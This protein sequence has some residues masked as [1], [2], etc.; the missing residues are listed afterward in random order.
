MILQMPQYW[1]QLQ[2]VVG[3]L[4]C[5]NLPQTSLVDADGQA[6]AASRSREAGIGCLFSGRI[7]GG[8]FVGPLAGAALLLQRGKHATRL[9]ADE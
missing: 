9:L 8:A 7:G 2:V 4:G 3:V 5:P 1:M 6:G